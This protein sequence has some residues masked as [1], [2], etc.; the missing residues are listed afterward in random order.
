MKNYKTWEVIGALAE[1]NN[2]KFKDSQGRELFSKYGAAMCTYGNNNN[3]KSLI[4]LDE[5][6]T[7]E[8]QPVDFMTAMKAYGGEQSTISCEFSSRHIYKWNSEGLK[9]ENGNPLNACEIL[10][11]KWF[12][13]E[14]K[15][16]V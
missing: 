12:I 7:L 4:N 1:N 3:S 8:Q 15:E 9:N 6:W 2:L 14:D 16:N 5:I 10:K 13:E 11:G